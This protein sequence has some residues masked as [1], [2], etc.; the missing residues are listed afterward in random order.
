MRVR[1]AVPVVLAL[2]AGS[3]GCK[4]SEQ[5]DLERERDSLVTQRQVLLVHQM[6]LQNSA[7]Q[8]AAANPPDATSKLIYFM[9]ERIAAENQLR[10]VD[11]RLTEIQYRLWEIDHPSQ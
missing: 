1:L 11:S 7:A 10:A 9:Q 2:V 8:V 6:N 3:S 5:R 4:S